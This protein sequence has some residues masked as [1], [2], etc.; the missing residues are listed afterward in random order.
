M[1]AVKIIKTSDVGT[2]K[3]LL[4]D[5][6]LPS[7]QSH[8]GQN[9]K[10]L[11][12]GGSNLFHASSLWSA[13][14]ASHVAD[15]V[16]Y[17][18]T[19]E[20]NEIFMGLKKKFRNGIIV[21]RK[22]IPNYIKEDDSVLLGPGMVR[23]EE[24]FRP[25]DERPIKNLEELDKIEHEGIQTY[26]LTKYILQNFPDQKYVID[27]GALQMMNPDWM[28][29]LKEKPI[30]T[31]HQK[32][33]ARL[34]G[35]DILN[36]T[37]DEKIK[38]VEEMAKKYHC[39]ILLKAVMDV[40]SDG[41]NTYVIEGGNVGLTK[42][43]TGDVIG[44][45]CAAFYSKNK[46]TISSVMASCIVKRTADVLFKEKGFWYNTENLIEKIPQIIKEIAL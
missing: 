2:I 9:G 42:G 3:P 19:K 18:S 17:S 44:G 7:A 26:Y 14:T 13:E 5:F 21:A 31:P 34:F 30:I 33:F 1:E 40:V 32:E 27:A 12:I 11:I 37:N 15:M 25:E 4:K 10:V 39:V 20:N 22:D 28:L 16:H 36:K 8:K 23:T 38:I 35:I 6:Y 24:I 46:A 41:E 43:G 45:L 29:D